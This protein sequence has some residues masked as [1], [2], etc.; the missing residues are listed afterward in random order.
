MATLTLPIQALGNKALITA[1]TE[2]YNEGRFLP[3]Y[4]VNH[5]PNS[6]LENVTIFAE[7]N[8][9]KARVIVSYKTHDEA[10]DALGK[11][12]SYIYSSDMENISKVERERNLIILTYNFLKL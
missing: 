2:A 7:S 8:L 10:F 4:W 6:K 12:K 11:I 1:L 9:I 5:L 3:G